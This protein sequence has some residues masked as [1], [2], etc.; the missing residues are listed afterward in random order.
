M[1]KRLKI[2]GILTILIFVFALNVGAW[3][4]FA[5]T[6]GNTRIASDGNWNVDVSDSTALGYAP[7]YSPVAKDIYGDSE[8]EL[9]ITDGSTIR[10]YNPFGS[11]QVEF[12]PPATV[13]SEI[14]LTSNYIVFTATDNLIYTYSYDGSTLNHVNNVTIIRGEAGSPYYNSTNKN[15]KCEIDNPTICFFLN[16]F[17]NVCEY[18]VENSVN[19]ATCYIAYNQSTTDSYKAAIGT[20]YAGDQESF[21]TK[22]DDKRIMVFDTNLNQI[23]SRFSSDGLYD[24]QVGNVPPLT[25]VSNPMVL[26]VDTLGNG[27]I[28]LNTFDAIAGNTYAEI[29]ILN[30]DGTDKVLGLS[31]SP[32]QYDTVANTGGTSYASDPVAVSKESAGGLDYQICALGYSQALQSFECLDFSIPPLVSFLDI[33]HTEDYP[34][35]GSAS[36]TLTHQFASSDADGDGNS[37]L[38]VQGGILNVVGSP[39]TKAYNFTFTRD[40]YNVFASDLNNDGDL[41][42]IL[43]NTSQALLVGSSFTNQPPTIF[44]NLSRGGYGSNLGYDSP[45]CL[46]STITFSAVEDTTYSNDASSDL[47]RIISNCGQ[48]GDGSPSASFTSGVVNGTY[49]TTTPIYQCTYNQSGIF[50]VRLYLQDDS[51]TVDFTQYNTETIVLNVIDGVNGVTCNLD[52]A[53]Q[54]GDDVVVGSSQVDDDIE[55]SL[56]ILLGTSTQLKLIVGIALLIGIMV[57]VA[58]HTHN[59][60]VLAGTGILGAIMLTFLGLLPTS[61]IIVILFGFIFLIFVGKF[62]LSPGNGGGE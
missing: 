58:Q 41:K 56:G 62:L 10:I 61:I 40:N 15:I 20:L 50:N 19:N 46:G 3:D 32:F 38:I 57:A 39:A 5:G 33:S 60:F 16:D 6:N 42:V 54:A 28:I 45:I 21:V 37:Q 30:S 25:A 23:D 17:G 55:A 35:L 7:K 14:T 44:N 48:Q 47:E 31:S 43:Y 18:D 12:T 36:K 34:T 59:G 11:A 24:A 53:T 22:V 13:N 27:E 1:N 26:N 29:E 4:Q 9:V 2:F 51:N 52:D 49:D 8:Q